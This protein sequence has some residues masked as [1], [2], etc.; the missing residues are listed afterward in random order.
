MCDNPSL[1]KF[2]IT[3]KEDSVELGLKN[4]PIY[5]L[6]ISTNELEW[7]C[8]GTA[9]ELDS[10]KC[11]LKDSILVCSTKI[12]EKQIVD[13]LNNEK[14]KLRKEKMLKDL[15]KKIAQPCK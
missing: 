7:L 6:K 13:E 9:R 14:E 11:I 15:A 5:K 4:E 12:R 2:E 10:I 3:E 1:V 8:Y